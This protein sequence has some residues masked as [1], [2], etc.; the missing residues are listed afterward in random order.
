VSTS[1]S[2]QR[3]RPLVLVTGA[4]GYI[5]SQLIGPLSA[6]GYRVRVSA[7]H[8]QRI[9]VGSRRHADEMVAADAFD[10]IEGDTCTTKTT[11]FCA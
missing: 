8:P 2:D 9:P 3:V 11:M 4:T 1:V 6:A 10:E 5:G 7:R